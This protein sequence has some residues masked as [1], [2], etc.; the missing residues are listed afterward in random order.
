MPCSW[1]SSSLFSSSWFLSSL[2]TSYLSLTSNFIMCC[3][4][5]SL[6]IQSS[7]LPFPHQACK[8]SSISVDFQILFEKSPQ[9]LPLSPPSLSPQVINKSN[10]LFAVP[11][12]HIYNSRPAVL[13]ISSAMPTFASYQRTCTRVRTNRSSGV[14]SIAE[15]V[16]PARKITARHAVSGWLSVLAISATWTS[17]C[18]SSMSVISVPRSTFYRRFA[19]RV[20]ASCSRSGSAVTTSIR[21]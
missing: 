14:F 12:A 17:F 8:T 13:R 11:A 3:I 15:W 18:P 21:H 6:S 10:L 9:L 7:S 2:L 20:P 5:P 19:S 1:S 4:I 16:S